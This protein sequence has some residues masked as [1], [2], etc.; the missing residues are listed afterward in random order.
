MLPPL[1]QPARLLA[2]AGLALA[3]AGFGPRCGAMVTELADGLTYV[4][5]RDL[6]T[7]PA[8]A[9]R[10]A[11][12]L[13]FRGTQ[14][15]AEAVGRLAPLLDVR[16]QGAMRLVLLDPTTSPAILERLKTASPQVLTLAATVEGLRVD[17][18]VATPAAND[19][20]A[21]DAI[22]AGKPLGELLEARREKRRYD[23]AAMVRDHANG[24]PLPDSPPD[25]TDP[26]PTS[27]T[28]STPAAKPEPK[29]PPPLQDTVLQRA[30]HVHQALRALKKV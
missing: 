1:L 16:A 30:I 26:A 19:Q 6:D 28:P 2:L 8:P 24:L 5:I 20:L 7:E 21:R 14:A 10:S 29:G 17:I 9:A 13:D 4:R 23:E 25:T 11:M 12:I 18:P 27:P 3:L 15:T 22:D